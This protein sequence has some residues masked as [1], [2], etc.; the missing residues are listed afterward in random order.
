MKSNNF[1]VTINNP[2]EDIHQW[3]DRVK[4]LGFSYGR[5][6]LERGESG[7]LHIQGCF[8]GKSTR[9]VALKKHFPTAHLEASK[10]PYKAWEYCGKDETRVEG[11]VEFGIPPAN[12]A[13]AGD[14]SA[15]N[16]LLL[17]KGA[18]KA[19]DDGDIPLV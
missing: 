2:D 19:V 14:Y 10:S 4:A 8:G 6:Q 5:A 7:T 3:L 13:R 11:P 9:L 16:K 18:A 15:R 12:R 17:A 1:I